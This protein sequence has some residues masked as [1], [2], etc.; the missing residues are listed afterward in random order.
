MQVRIKG[1]HPGNVC[2]LDE[3]NLVTTARGEPVVGT[4]IRGS[5]TKLRHPP[6]RIP[7]SDIHGLF[8]SC[9]GEAGIPLVDPRVIL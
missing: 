3:L 8:L 4:P 5:I 1:R 7:A 9:C 2:G 6:A